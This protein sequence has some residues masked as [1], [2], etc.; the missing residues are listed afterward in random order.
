MGGY[1][2]DGINFPVCTVGTYNCMDKISGGAW[3]TEIVANGL[4]AILKKRVPFS[5]EFVY[6]VADFLCHKM[7]EYGLVLEKAEYFAINNKTNPSKNELLK[8]YHMTLTPSGGASS[9]VDTCVWTDKGGRRDWYAA[10]SCPFGLKIHRDNPHHP[11]NDTEWNLYRSN[12]VIRANSPRMYGHFLICAEEHDFETRV[13]LN[14][15][16]QEKLGES[17]GRILDMLCTADSWNSHGAKVE[18]LSMW[19]ET[20]VLTDNLS[21]SGV[22]WCNDFHLGKVCISLC[23]GH[24]VCNN[25]ASAGRDKGHVD[26]MRS[27]L[28]L[29]KRHLQLPGPWQSFHVDLMSSLNRFLSQAST[30]DTCKGWWKDCLREALG[31]GEVPVHISTERDERAASSAE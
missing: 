1:A 16:V 3:P 18:V 4:F 22:G 7:A 11:V 21:S 26:N 19:E 30:A 9:V 15:L 5:Y 20:L 2:V 6:E 13:L 8:S 31:A 14:V 25:L 29:L 23:G 24:M 17:L 28:K 10:V 27:A 12:L